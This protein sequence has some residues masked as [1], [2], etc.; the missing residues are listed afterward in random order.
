MV[1]IIRHRWAW[2]ALAVLVFG[3]AFLLAVATTQ[4]SAA[5]ITPG[6]MLQSGSVSTNGVVVGVRRAM[7]SGVSVDVEIYVRA[8]A[9]DSGFA[10]AGVAAGDTDM[11][12]VVGLSVRGGAGGGLVVT[13]PPT[14]WPVGATAAPLSVRAVRVRDTAGKLAVIAGDWNLSVQLPR[15]KDAETARFVQALEPVVAIVAGR[16]MVVATL[17]THAATVVRY[18]LPQG[19][20]SSA[21]PSLKAGSG[22][23]LRPIRHEQKGGVN[24][25]W[26]AATPGEGP[27]VLALNGLVVSARESTAWSLSVA[28][29]SD[30][31]PPP[32]PKIAG[33]EEQEV[34]WVAQPRGDGPAIRS[35]AWWRYMQHVRLNVTVAGLWDPVAGGRP[36]A[37]GDGVELNV[38]GVVQL[39][40][41]AERAAQTI[42]T[43]ELPNSALPRN[44]VVTAGGRAVSVP[45]MEVILQP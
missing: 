16:E 33:P 18:E 15:G 12:G 45:S 7:F 36:V 8:E 41:T 39:P 28:L 6:V 22:K 21:P 42:I 29:E 44:L 3:G 23:I 38:I 2:I 5:E 34:R 26:F 20:T 9:A 30:N 11:G 24:E 14:A 10:V 32:D 25:V 19:V 1:M 40:S 17:K 27:L 4:Q 35:V 43:V 13:F 37:V 31:L